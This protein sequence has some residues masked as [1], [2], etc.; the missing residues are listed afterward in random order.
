MESGEGRRPG[1]DGG[2][3]GS[4]RGIAGEAKADHAAEQRT[5]RR[6]PNKRHAETIAFQ[7]D[8]SRYQLTAGY[9]PDGRLGEV[10]IN[11]DRADSLLDVLMSDA[12]IAVS[13]ALQ[14]G[15]PIDELRHALKRDGRGEPASPIG[16]ALELVR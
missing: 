10:F 14:Y 9:F 4:D 8:G 1:R 15:A 5:R 12:A 7:R 6:L 2:A 16:A 13:L 11:A 3:S